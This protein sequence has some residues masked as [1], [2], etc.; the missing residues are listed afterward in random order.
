MVR[1]KK[2]SCEALS[3]IFRKSAILRLGMAHCAII[4]ACK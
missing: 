4:N 1:G 3:C 2:L